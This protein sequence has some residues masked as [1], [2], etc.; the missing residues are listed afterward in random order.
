L[1]KFLKDA[2][3]YDIETSK[4]NYDT[5][6]KQ[7]N[8]ITTKITDL[9]EIITKNILHTLNVSDILFIP[10]K[11]ILPLFNSKVQISNIRTVDSKDVDSINKIHKIIINYIKT[12]LN[13]FIDSSNIVN[14]EYLN[15]QNSLTAINTYFNNTPVNINNKNTII[16]FET[17]KNNELTSIDISGSYNDY[18]LGCTKTD[19]TLS[20][21]KCLDFNTY[22]YVNNLT[23]DTNDTN[24]LQSLNIDFNG[25]NFSGYCPVTTQGSTTTPTTVPDSTTTPATVP[26]STITS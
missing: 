26:D 11:D 21:E 16:A 5:N 7:Y 6:K 1:R 9:Q 10:I 22:T 13:S 20:C 24:C 3:L 18:C 17:K 8:D 23:I 14:S 12:L 4:K 2:A 15:I 19:T 25:S